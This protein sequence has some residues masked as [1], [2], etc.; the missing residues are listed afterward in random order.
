MLNFKLNSERQFYS[1]D[2]LLP[3]SCVFIHINYNLQ[4]V[5]RSEKTIILKTLV[6]IF[7]ICLFLVL[8]ITFFK[9]PFRLQLIYSVISSTLSYFSS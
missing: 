1:Q 6:I 2:I 8:T 9:T 4:D 5:L 7:F 3:V